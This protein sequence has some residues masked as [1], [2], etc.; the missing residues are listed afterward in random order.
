[1]IVTLNEKKTIASP[2]Y[3]FVF[4]N[5]STKQTV[6]K[7]YSSA[8]DLSPYPDRYNK[9][10]IVVNS[11]FNNSDE[12]MWTYNVYEQAGAVNTNPTGL[13]EVESGIMRLKGAAFEYKEYDQ[14]QT[15]KQY[16][17]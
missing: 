2:Y 4:T 6:T 16:N 11:F 8:D 9:F 15:F 10:P 14:Q 5:S 13:K 12:G 3:L 7:I 17:G 1:M